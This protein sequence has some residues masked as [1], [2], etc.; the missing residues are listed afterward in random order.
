MKDWDEYNETLLQETTNAIRIINKLGKCRALYFADSDRKR[1]T[2]LIKT[3]L[4]KLGHSL[5]YK[6]YANGLKK[7]DLLQ[8]NVP[9]V[10]REWLFDVHWYTEGIEPYSILT[11]PL[12]AECEWNPRL[13]GDGKTSYSGIKY[14]FQKL[15][16][17]NAELRLMIFIIKKI[18]DLEKLNIY[19]ENVIKNYA[20]LGR[21][22]NFLF[23]AFYDKIKSFYYKRIR[24]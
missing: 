15:V 19:F 9:F 6:V 17:S 1:R 5:D 2:R 8:I 10:N 16:V 12:V 22:S 11:L 7:D 18:K 20:H 23:I 14:D 21:D 13:R 3:E 4:A 24:K